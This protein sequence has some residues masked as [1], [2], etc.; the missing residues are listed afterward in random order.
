MNPLRIPTVAVTDVVDGS[1]RDAVLLDVREDDEWRAGHIA[2]AVHVPMNDVP[3]RLA[4]EPDSLSA[5]TPV[6]VVCASGGRSAR[7]TAWLRQQ[8]YDAMNLEGGM[9]AWSAAGQPMQAEGGAAP[10]V[11]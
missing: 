11:L 6:V 10:R 2:R 9:H 4:E 5:D 7:V 3:S 8:G 1:W